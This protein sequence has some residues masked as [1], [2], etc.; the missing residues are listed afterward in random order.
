MSY[1]DAYDPLDGVAIIAVA[2]R[3]PG[4]RDVEEFWQNLVAG[5]ETI[6]HFSEDELEPA[7]PVDMESRRDQSY[8]RARG[9]IDDVELFDA[10]F[11]KMSPREAE[12]TDPQQRVFLET[13][14][15]ALERAGYDSETYD[16]S[17]GVYAGMSNNTYFLANL[18][19][20]PDVL[21][22]A[23]ELAMLGNEKDYLATRVSYKLNLRGPS[24]NIVTACSSSLVA[25][26]QAVQ[27]LAT[28]Q[29][30]MALAGGVSIRVPQRRG[31]LYQEGFITSP[32][33]HC[34]AFDEHAAG[35][36]FSNGLGIVVL[37]RLDEALEDG[38]TIYAVI[39]GAAVNNDG[40]G[41][42]SFTAPSVNGQADAVA[43]AQALAGID[44]DT[45]SYVEAHGT[46]TA[47]GDPVEIAGLA[48]AF[49]AITEERGYCALGSVKTNIGH[50]DAAAGVTGLIKTA[51]ALHH[52]TLPPTLHFEA[53]SPELDLPNTPFFINAKLSEWPEQSGPRRAGVSSLGAGGTNAHVVLEEAPQAVPGDD[54]RPEQL[55]LLSARSANALDRSAE[56]LRAHLTSDAD[57]SLADAAYTLQVGRRRFDHR[58]AIVAKC[59]EEAIGLLESGGTGRVTGE[60]Q[61]AQR[62]PVAF[63]FPGQGAQCANMGRG[64]Y[65]SEPVFRAEVDDCA[66]ILREHL[67]RDLRTLLYPR[68]EDAPATQDELA[69]TAMTQPAVFVTSYALTKLWQHWGV[70]VDAML[71]HS[72]GDFVA[73]CV[74]GVFTREDALALVARRG[75]LMQELPSGAM[76]AVRADAQDIGSV[77]GP[78]VTIAGYNSPKLTVISGDHEAIA[79]AAELL[80]S[81]GIVSK[82]L[83]TSHAFHSSMMEPIVDGFARI[84]AEV[85]RQ[86]PQTPFI[87]SLTG[88]WITDGEAT[89]PAFWA[90]QLREPVRFAEGAAKLLHDPRRVLLEVGPGQTLTRMLRQQPGC[91]PSRAVVASL[92]RA[93]DRGADMHSMLTAVGRLWTAG[94]VFDWA[95]LHG[96]SRRRR[97]PLPTYPFERKRYWVDPGRT[98]AGQ[99]DSPGPARGPDVVDGDLITTGTPKETSE[100]NMS[101]SMGVESATGQGRRANVTARLQTL[102]S[103]L[104][105]LE[106][107]EL[108]PAAS[109]VELGLDSLFLTQASTAIHKT[110]GV[111]VAFRDLLEDASTLD[112]VAARIDAELPPDVAPPAP[113]PPAP[114][115]PAH[116]PSPAV[117]LPV[118][119]AVAGDLFER[120]VTRQM[121]LMSLQ[122]ET[123]RGRDA[124][125]PPAASP[126][127]AASASVPLPPRK[128][129]RPPPPR[130]TEKP[131]SNGSIAFGP[132]RPP[133]KEQGGGLTSTQDAA[134]AAF[135]ERYE[136]R[137]AASKRFTAAN[138]NHLADP[139]SV[140]GFRLLWKEIVYPIVTS[141]SAGSKL[142][143]LDGNEYIDLTNGFGMILFGHNPPF[144]REAIE[145]QLQQG[146]EIGPQTTL[147]ADV[148]R[149]VSEMTGMERVAF[150]N[151][152]S[153]AVTAAI[154]MARTVSGRDT[155][156]M[157]AGA[158]HGVSD[159]VLVRPTKVEGQLRSVPIAPGIAP[160]MVE[161]IMVLEYGSPESLAILK[162]RGSELAAVLVEPVQSRRPELQ[163]VEFLRELRALTAKS[164]TALVFDEVV[165]GFRAH[166]GGVQSLFGIRADI[167]T[168][169]KVV[170]G[171]LPIGLVAGSGK[172]MD[173]LDGGQWAYGDRS[174]PEVGVTFFAGTF[175]RHPLALAAARAVL[176]RL[177]SEGPDLQRTLNIRTTHLVD[178]LNTHAEEVGAP[179]RVTSFAS[180][181]CFNFPADVPH[182]SLFYAYMRDKGI[183]VWEGRAGFLT[184]AHTDDDIARVVSAFKETLAEMQAADFLPAATG[185]P[186]AG[187]RRGLDADGREAWF[188]PD[189]ARP[190]QY[191]RVEEV[192]ADHG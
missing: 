81:R 108:E 64:L 19:H 162:A 175:V 5:K 111:K 153:E 12:V 177:R 191:L 189:P 45:I 6:S 60:P 107:S 149:T 123:L 37:K 74:A 30:D 117:A 192:T 86:T 165:S 134:L 169:G 23:G 48:Q 1:A 110:F 95:A 98:E 106:E 59:P 38:D 135:I 13:A 121:E 90:R 167:A 133:A 188:V 187:A 180:W 173:A 160:N 43:M 4:A 57:I 47:L 146:F 105:G 115:P 156:A 126:D 71:G 113:S 34:R 178:E 24:I 9:I 67:D 54:A 29:C 44:P 125:A 14:S 116:A 33:G 31:Y 171:G 50:L 26:C 88:D 35:T 137:T 10:G 3:F 69:Q 140:A 186:I 8:V 128:T 139:R 141:R 55:L 87:S 39:K 102:F 129:E 75:R 79:S 127:V 21:R 161:N 68:D 52:K 103:E 155:I 124:S 72:L 119:P 144:I 77:L 122:L 143:D 25:V 101:R 63:L 166:Q 94:T 91:G 46:G 7:D 154:R 190:G 80:E 179:L 183:H 100:E 84:V 18:H 158:Y 145:A 109:F 174:F 163:P 92:P 168:Y 65:E 170:G 73:A 130:K 172:Y 41:R 120:V 96:H 104:S 78:S 62:P 132:Y 176:E 22:N 89:D 181:F 82:A 164:D 76:M 49:G 70:E 42:V 112:A 51:L 20:R 151:T 152:G 182:A 83:A 138:R 114:S 15:E 85:P 136:R 93:G 157:F 40:S 2:G 159:E 56:L 36:V 61:E 148:S 53:P 131:A 97:L 118:A 58:I 17:I 99:I 28:H 27:A 32:D 66:E 11:F 16:G 150:C 147:A 184:T 185:P 142:W